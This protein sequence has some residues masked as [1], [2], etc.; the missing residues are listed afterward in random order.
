MCAHGTQKAWG[1]KL[2]HSEQFMSRMINGKKPP[3]DAMLKD[4]GLK[5]LVIYVDENEGDL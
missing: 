3:S 4:L 1:E 5:K 2:G